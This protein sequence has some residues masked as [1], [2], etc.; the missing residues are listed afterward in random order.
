MPIE[1]IHFNQNIDASLQVGDSTYVCTINTD[2]VATGEPELL[3]PVMSFTPDSITVQANA[4]VT[5]TVGQYFL[6]SK[7][8]QVNESGLKGYYAD[9]TFENSSRTYVEL[10]AISSEV[11]SSSK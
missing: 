5:L 9:V 3:G 8:I 4:A 2:G 7:P 1:T 10:F 6:F 11:V